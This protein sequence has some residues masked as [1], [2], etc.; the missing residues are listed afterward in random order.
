LPGM[1]SNMFLSLTYPPSQSWLSA[2]F[3]L[4]YGMRGSWHEREKKGPGILNK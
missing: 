1:A 4:P 2:W 3:N